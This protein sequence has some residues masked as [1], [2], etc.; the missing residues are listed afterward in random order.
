MPYLLDTSVFLNAVIAPDRLNRR[1]QELLSRREAVLFLSAASSWEIAIKY[2]IGK[3]RMPDAPARWVPA[4]M[5]RLGAHPLD[6]AHRHALEVADL[7]SFHQDPFDRVLIV[8]A[9]SEDLVLLTADRIF[10]KYPVEVILC[11]S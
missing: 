1:A 11:G 7:P 8:Q 2:A 3:L 10:Q 6:I 5:R 9:K 4:A